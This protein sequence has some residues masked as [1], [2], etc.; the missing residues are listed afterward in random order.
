MKKKEIR[1]INIAD[2]V[3]E[4]YDPEEVVAFLVSKLKSYNVRNG[5]EFADRELAG[6]IQILE[7]L[8]RKM[9]GGSGAVIL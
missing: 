8:S 7:A 5:Q 4:R 3:V 9:G 6:Y 1:Q 2:L